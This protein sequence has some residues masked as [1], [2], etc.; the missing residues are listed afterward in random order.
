[1]MADSSFCCTDDFSVLIPY[2]KL[3]NLLKIAAGYD[4]LLIR[5]KRLEEQLQALHARDLEFMDKLGE[6]Q[7]MI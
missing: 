3:E 4:D 1:M 6:I 7:K 5:I 2:K